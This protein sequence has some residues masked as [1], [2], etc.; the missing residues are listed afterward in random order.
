MRERKKRKEI[1][2][3]KGK[4]RE[5]Y[6][7]FEEERRDE[8]RN[9]L[10]HKARGGRG[11]LKKRSRYPCRAETSKASMPFSLCLFLSPVLFSYIAR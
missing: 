9:K 4:V 7:D 10:R 2:I 8:N 3:G 1:F 5:G 6:K 11:K